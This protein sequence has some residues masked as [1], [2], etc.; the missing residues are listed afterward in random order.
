MKRRSRVLPAESS[1]L[2]GRDMAGRIGQAFDALLDVA[3]RAET[4]FDRLARHAV[5]DIGRNRVAQAVELVDELAAARGE[6]QTIS[7]PV[8]W[9]VP[10]LQQPV[11]DQAI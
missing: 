5:Q 2:L 6:K 10:P 7:A 11:F 4:G 1:L 9:V 3:Q 8:L